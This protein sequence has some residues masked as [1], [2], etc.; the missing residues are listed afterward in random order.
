MRLLTANDI[1]LGMVV[2]NVLDDLK[3]KLGG[4]RGY[5]GKRF[6]GH[7]LLTHRKQIE[8]DK[9]LLDIQPIM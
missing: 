9:I 4:T 2:S 3:R 1:P 5:G 8:I 6:N 7:W